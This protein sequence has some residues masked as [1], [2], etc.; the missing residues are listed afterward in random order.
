MRGRSG[1]VLAAVHRAFTLLS[2]SQTERPRVSAR[3]GHGLHLVIDTDAH[4]V[5][6][7]RF[8]R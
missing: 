3:D 1:V 8:M 5:A 2:E 7:L 6:E 4:S